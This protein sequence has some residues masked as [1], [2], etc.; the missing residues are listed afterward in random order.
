[1]VKFIWHDGNVPQGLKITQVYGI[2]FT[3]DGRILIA[4]R[5]DKN[6]N[7]YYSLAG[8]RQSLLIKILKTL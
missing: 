6:G 1:M 5:K 8:G 2:I 4:K 7:T 3:K